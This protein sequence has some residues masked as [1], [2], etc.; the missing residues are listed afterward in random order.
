[1]DHPV[2]G[3]ETEYLCSADNHFQ[4]EVVRVSRGKI[5]SEYVVYIGGGME[6]CAL[7]ST[8]RGQLLDLKVGGSVGA[9]FSCFAVILRADY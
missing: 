3:G 2:S 7:I 9:A 4:G 8:A 6:L 1:M 5:I